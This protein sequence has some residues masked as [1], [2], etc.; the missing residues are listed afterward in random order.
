MF[1][2]ALASLFIGV[3]LLAL[4]TAGFGVMVV[5]YDWYTTVTW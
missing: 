1:R 2:H 5:A 4:L 3:V